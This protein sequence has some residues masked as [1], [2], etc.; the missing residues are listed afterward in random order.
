MMV[1]LE[2]DFDILVEIFEGLSGTPGLELVD[3]SRL[4]TSTEQQAD[5]RRKEMSLWCKGCSHNYSS[6]VAC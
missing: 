5:H 4:L 6:V 3:R 1:R 2:H